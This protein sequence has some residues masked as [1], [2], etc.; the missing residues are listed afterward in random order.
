MEKEY[1]YH[2]ECD[3]VVTSF[4]KGEL[5]KEDAESKLIEIYDKAWE[6]YPDSEPDGDIEYCITTA[7]EKLN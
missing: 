2:K 1:D 3:K 7:T 5:V 6:V 4:K